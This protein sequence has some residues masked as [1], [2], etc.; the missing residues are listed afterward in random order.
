MYIY[1]YVH[2]KAYMHAISKAEK[3]VQE[4]EVKQVWRKGKGECCN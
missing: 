2:T 4:V 1:V 3:G